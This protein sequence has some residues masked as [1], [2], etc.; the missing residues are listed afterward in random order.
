MLIGKKEC[1]IFLHKYVSVG[2][3]S[4]NL[5]RPFYL[6]GEVIEVTED[7]LTVKM[8]NGYKQIY[9]EDLVEIRVAKRAG[10]GNSDR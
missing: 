6:S 3:P 1:L 9:F 10:R 2:V 8:P 7:Y 4:F 5:G